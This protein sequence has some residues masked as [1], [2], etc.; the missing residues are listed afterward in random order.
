MMELAQGGNRVGTGLNAQS[1][2]KMVAERIARSPACQFHTA[3]KSRGPGRHAAMVFSNGAINHG[4]RQPVQ[5]R[6]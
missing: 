6:Q 4:G 2:D 3:P 5:D 1:F